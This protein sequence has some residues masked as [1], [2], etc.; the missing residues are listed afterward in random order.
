ME[1]TLKQLKAF[2]ITAEL[3]NLTDAADKLHI[4][5]PAVS[6]NIQ[7]LEAQ[8]NNKLFAVSGK[9]LYLTD[10]GERLLSL[11]RPYLDATNA[12]KQQIMQLTQDDLPT[13]KI[14]VTNTVQNYVFKK[15]GQFQKIHPYINFEISTTHWGKQQAEIEKNK[16]DFIVVSEPNPLPKKYR[17]AILLEYHLSL[18]AH[19]RH[20]LKGLKLSL[21]NIQNLKFIVCNDESPSQTWQ[22]KIIERW[23]LAS[24]PI[25]LDS[26]ASIYEATVAGIGV[27]LLP[28]IM[29]K[30][31]IEHGTLTPLHFNYKSPSFTLFLGSKKEFN[32]SMVIFHQFMLDHP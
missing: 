13:L 3:L 23:Q 11:T 31:S 16:Y 28:D 5:P 24:K 14:L 29:V 15:I 4:S 30:E 19:G 27:A 6:K 2:F 1:F 8:C 32:E 26:Y 17:N 20:S 21:K 18:V 10:F 25:I 9:K 22:S 7:N 12:F